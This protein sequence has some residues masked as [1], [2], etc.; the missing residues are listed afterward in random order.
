MPAGWYGALED[1]HLVILAFVIFWR[2]KEILD[3][4][5]SA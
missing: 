3:A 1:E 5:L 2:Y 4:T